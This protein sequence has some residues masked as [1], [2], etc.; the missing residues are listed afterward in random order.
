MPDTSIKKVT[1][2]LKDAA[3]SMRL[4]GRVFAVADMDHAIRESVDVRNSTPATMFLPTGRYVYEFDVQ[5][6]S[7]AF[8]VAASAA[9]QGTLAGNTSDGTAGRQ[10]RFKVVG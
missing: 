4:K 5:S 7:G 3:S 9:G 6:A 8:T 10:L 2:E 1:L